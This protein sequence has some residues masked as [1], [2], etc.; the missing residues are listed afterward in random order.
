MVE[1]IGFI[2]DPN[3]FGT[4]ASWEQYIAELKALPDSFQDKQVLIA[5]A[6]LIL[7]K[8]LASGQRR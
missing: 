6:E 7:A 2:D 4:L 5:D 1:V 8:K 3:P